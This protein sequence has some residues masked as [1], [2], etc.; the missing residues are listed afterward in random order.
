MALSIF[1]V[2]E[3]LHIEC[4]YIPRTSPYGCAGICPAWGAQRNRMAYKALQKHPAAI[5][6]RVFA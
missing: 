5:C 2:Y 4:Y 6:S 3:E 1:S